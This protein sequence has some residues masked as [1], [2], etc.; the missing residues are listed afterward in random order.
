MILPAG[1]GPMAYIIA[2]PCIG[3]KDTACV[4]VCPVDSKVMQAGCMAS[5]WTVSFKVTQ[6]LHSLPMA[7]PSVF[8]KADYTAS[9][10][11]HMKLWFWSLWSRL[12]CKETRLWLLE[13]RVTL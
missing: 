3:T 7:R 12:W 8:S 11:T 5:N 6:A 9:S 1:L 4:D 13:A 2:E 10:L